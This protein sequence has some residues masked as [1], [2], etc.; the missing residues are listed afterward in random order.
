MPNVMTRK[1]KSSVIAL[2]ERSTI[3]EVID[4]G[5]TFESNRYTTNR[6]SAGSNKCKPVE[7]QTHRT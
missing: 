7:A 4:K 2:S 6:T 3:E 1:W 5:I